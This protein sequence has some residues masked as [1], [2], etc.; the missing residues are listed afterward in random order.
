MESGELPRISFV[1]RIWSE[2][3]LEPGAV[4]VWRGQIVEVTSGARR[5]VQNIDEI[6][7]FVVPYLEA[8]GVAPGGL[9]RCRRWLNGLVSRVRAYRPPWPGGPAR[10]G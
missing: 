9:S 3:V 6:W 4:A 10:R 2:G 7:D 5:T 8:M 1:L